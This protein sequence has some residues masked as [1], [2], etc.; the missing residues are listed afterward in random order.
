MDSVSRCLLS[1]GAHSRIR[2]AG[3]LMLAVLGLG[4]CA[5][6]AGAGQIVQ[7]YPFDDP[8]WADSGDGRSYEVPALGTVLPFEIPTIDGARTIGHPGTPQLPIHVARIL[9]PPGEE[10]SAVRAIALAPTETS[11]RLPAPAGSPYPLSWEGPVEPTAPNEDLYASASLYPAE[12]A[13]WVT[14]QIYRGHRVA[15]IELFPLRA[16]LAAGEVD[17]CGSLQLIVETAPSEA[18]LTASAR[19]YRPAATTAAWLERNTDNPA[20]AAEYEAACRRGELVRPEPPVRSIVDPADHYL[21]VVIT[22]ESLAPVYEPLA[23]DRTARGLPATI[24]TTTEIYANYTGVDA[25]EQIRNFILDAYQGWGIEYVLLAGDID[26]I[27]DRDCYVYIIDE[28][29]PM[30]TNNLCCDL[31]YEGLDATWNDD[32]D[33][34]WGE[35]GEEDLVPDIY[36]GRVCADNST[37]AQNFIDKL[38]AYERQPVLGDVETAAFF[39]EYLWTDTWGEMYMEEIRL[40]SD[41]WGYTTA[42]VP[43]T[44]DTYTYY[45]M[46]GNWNGSDYIN[47]MNSGTHQM[48]H[49]GHSSSSYNAKVYTSD[50]SSFTANGVDHIH[51]V[52]YSQGCDAGSFDT[53]DAILEQFILSPTGYVAWVGNTRYGF[54]IHYTTNGSSQYYHRQYVDALFGEG[55][56]RLG[57]ANGDSRAD[58]VGYID[59]EA[60]RWV[61]YE[62]TAF[63]DP[64]M[65]VWT[66]AP[67][68]PLVSH[69]GVFVLGNSEY[70]VTV[71]AAGEPVAGARV[72]AWDQIGSTYAYGITGASGEVTLPLDPGQPG[73]LHLIVSD[74]NL[75]VTEFEV[76]IV[77]EGPYVIVY[78]HEIDDLTG[79]NGDGDADIGEDIELRVSLQNVWSE[80]ITGVMG[81]ISSENEH[82]TCTEPTVTYGSLDPGEIQMPD[83]GQGFRFLVHGDCPDQET[84]TFVITIQDDAEHEWDGT[85]VYVMNAPLVDLVDLTVDDSATGDGDGLLDPGESALLTVRLSNGGHC[86]AEAVTATL[87][88]AHPHLTI[89]QGSASA[90]LIEVGAEAVLAPPFEVAL[91]AGAESPGLISCSLQLEGDWT[92]EALLPLDVGVGGFRDDMEAGEG[93]WAH[94]V[95][96]PTFEDQWHRSSQRNHTAGGAHSWKFGDTGSGDHANLADGALVTPVIEV[97]E[98]S[99]LTF[100]H[101]MDAETS[102]SY[103]QY[104][105]DGGLI[106]I[107]VD[108]GAWEQITP[109][110][111]YSH[112]V[113]EGG[114][115]GP[116]AAETPIFSGT[117]DWE[118]VT[119]TMTTEPGTI[120]L[121][122]R[123]G[124]DGAVS[125]EG[126]FIDDVHL[127]S[128]GETSGI[129]IEAPLALRPALGANR[130]N[131][132]P[133]TTRL[134]LHMPEAAEARVAILDAT[135]RVVK[136]LLEGHLAAGQHHL[137][138]NGRNDAGQPVATGIYF[139]RLDAAGTAQVRK[140]TLLR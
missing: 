110:Q 18:A 129:E 67:Q 48:H 113:R 75:L 58:N 57:A 95:V 19:T 24:V 126:W 96:T 86:P 116:F 45:E 66:A 104:A 133:A 2:V 93:G 5:G 60:N 71:E 85:A 8:I 73:T 64:A 83:P 30:E 40:G 136:T 70:T 82:V 50:I 35:P 16:R 12:A 22:S 111:G 92:Y 137:E 77:P 46:S 54:G 98:N 63:G 38:L 33:D 3:T 122:F 36:T 87:L 121:R 39:G 34:R 94:E 119:C 101:W 102:S 90:P 125:Q 49:L 134:S 89:L 55:I 15:Y 84:V 25:Q 14:T 106:E 51:N 20:L 105:Y 118:L 23:A 17:F 128:W 132:F 131:P 44:W 88:A 120:Q 127:R 115:P 28:G 9:L 76:P 21:Y 56:H 74:A 112:L 103:P 97:A 6:A 99:V 109:D 108:G 114:T 138:W 42:G 11:R 140:M 37:E 68:E 4:A 32:Q 43:L 135:G 139:Y 27:P 79:G 65:P 62:I 13:R 130:P 7:T 47:R 81:T 100:W 26:V 59:Y 61:H 107:S 124:S 41:S 78:D 123:F 29:N 1:S 117:H 80:P 91:D 72:C 52:G 69:A 10:V 53:S 31:Y